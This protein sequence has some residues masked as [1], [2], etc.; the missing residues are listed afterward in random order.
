MVV[1][2]AIFIEPLAQAIRQN[3]D[4]RGVKVNGTK[5]KIGLFADDVVAYLERPSE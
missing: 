5:H 2:I 3:Q 1:N 4:I